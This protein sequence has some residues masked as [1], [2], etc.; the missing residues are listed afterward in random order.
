MRK[1][2]CHQQELHAI[3]T[4]LGAACSQGKTSTPS[5]LR[6]I[7]SAQ[8]VVDGLADFYSA[9]LGPIFYNERSHIP[10]GGVPVAMKVFEIPELLEYIL[11]YVSIPDIMSFQQVSR[12]IYALIDHS[13]A[14]LRR[15]SL[16]AEPYGSD[17]KTPFKNFTHGA[18]G[19]FYCGWERHAEPEKVV[20]RAGFHKAGA[21]LPYIGTRWCRM[22]ICQPPIKWMNVHLPCCSRQRGVQTE[23]VCS[24]EGITIGDLYDATLR[25]KQEHSGCVYASADRH[26]VDG[27]VVVNPVF[28]GVATVRE[29]DTIAT[30]RR[31]PQYPLEAAVTLLSLSVEER[32]ASNRLPAYIKYKR[33]GR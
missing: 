32:I 4:K 6:T 24:A 10:I 15:L 22:F 16:R 31:F 2:L 25:F 26:D 9:F 3:L 27:V 1:E 12:S 29:D 5:I 30:W 28:T 11:E 18:K 21:G 14:L 17:I 23:I 13:P 7:Q 8:R 33:R 19:G 20:V